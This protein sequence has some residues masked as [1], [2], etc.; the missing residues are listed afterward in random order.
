MKFEIVHT[1]RLDD[2]QFAALLAILRPPE[3]PIADEPPTTSTLTE[4]E[5]KF[6]AWI[7]DQG[8]PETQDSHYRAA[9]DVTIGRRPVPMGHSRAALREELKEAG[10]PLP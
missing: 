6:F 7:E 3:P 5:R 1:H 2:A 8:F 9:F 10:A 4:H